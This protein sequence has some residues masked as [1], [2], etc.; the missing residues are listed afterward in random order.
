MIAIDIPSLFLVIGIVVLCATTA[1]TAL[2]LPSLE[3]RRGR[4]GSE[5]GVVESLAM[6]RPMMTRRVVTG[7]PASLPQV[8]SFLAPAAIELPPAPARQNARVPDGPRTK[9]DDAQDFISKLI[10]DEPERLAELMMQWMNSD[11]DDAGRGV[12]R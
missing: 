11:P 4:R 6:E 1:V 7:R 3:W 10:D 2:S 5:R 9:V 12:E 8:S